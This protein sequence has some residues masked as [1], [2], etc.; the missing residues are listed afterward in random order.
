MHQA[1][2]QNAPVF[3]K[4]GVIIQAVLA[5]S[6]HAATLSELNKADSIFD[7]NIAVATFPAGA[8]LDWHYHPG[9]QILVITDGT[10]YY[11]ERGKPKQIVH[12]G[13]IIK[14]LPGVEHWH[15][16]SVKEGVTY[17]ATNPAKKGSTVWLQQVTDEEYRDSN[18]SDKK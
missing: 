3:K 10:G 8:K 7:F 1:E 17:M 13:D 2:A 4:N 15:G 9:G 5:D 6:S 11:Q 14:C 18:S 16:T 12:K